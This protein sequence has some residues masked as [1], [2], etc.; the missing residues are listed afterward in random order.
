M[1][2]FQTGG[3]PR[4]AGIYPPN[5]PVVES[6]ASGVCSSQ[7]GK[8][9]VDYRVHFGLQDNLSLMDDLYLVEY[10]VLFPLSLVNSMH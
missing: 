2:L 4:K 8:Y 9:A 7:P 10:S 3:V 5:S 1:I 6:Q